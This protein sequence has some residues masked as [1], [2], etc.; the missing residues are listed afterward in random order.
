MAARQQAVV[1]V[2]IDHSNDV[3]ALGVTTLFNDMYL[4]FAAK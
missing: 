2:P 1:D 4:N 3:A